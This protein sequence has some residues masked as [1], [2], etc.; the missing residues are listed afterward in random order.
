[1][2]DTS[3]HQQDDGPY[4]YAA[5]VWSWPAVPTGDPPH[6]GSTTC[7]KTAGPE[8]ATLDGCTNCSLKAWCQQ[9][10]P[11]AWLTGTCMRLPAWLSW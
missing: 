6:D 7:A 9:L 3:I 8:Q 1:M 4:E 10:M 5:L 11:E 2:R